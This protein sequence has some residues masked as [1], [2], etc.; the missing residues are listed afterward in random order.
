[1]T[2]KLKF[3]D[4]TELDNL[5]MNGNTF[6]SQTEVTTETLNEEAL[7]EVTVTD[8]EGGENVIRYARYDTIFHEEDGWHFVLFGASSDEIKY[9]ELKEDMEIA[10]NE[11]LDFVI[12]GEE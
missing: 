5:E 1:M 9:R 3:A 6:I 7:E 11:L 4:G 2:Y 12:G 8:S 10:L